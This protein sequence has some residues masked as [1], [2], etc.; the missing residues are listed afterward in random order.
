VNGKQITSGNIEDNLQPLLSSVQAQIYELRRRDLTRKVNDVLLAQEA[1]KRHVTTRALLDAEVTAKAPAITEA[2]A[3]KFYDENKDKM[4]G[5]A[6]AD[7]KPQIIA[8]LE[9]TEMDKLRQTFAAALQKNAA[10]QDFLVPP[11]T[12]K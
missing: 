6:F 5:G 2:Q 11:T 8:Y 9:R 7:V 1:Q 12:A 10:I 3:Q 4:K